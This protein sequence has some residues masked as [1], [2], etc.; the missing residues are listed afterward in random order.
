M[1]AD[2]RPARR[3]E[4]TAVVERYEW[5]FAPPGSTPPVW[6]EAVAAERVRALIDSDRATVL[7]TDD[8]SGFCTVVLD[9]P[10][11]RFGQRAWVEDLAIDPSRRSEGLGKQ[12]LDAAKQ[13]AVEHGATHLELDS[14]DGRLDAHRFYERE[15]PSWTSRCFGWWLA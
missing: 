3:T 4:T 1:T 15:Q 10:S 14:G 2:I 6:D 7:V 9:L 12:L 8:L 5:L 13:W 11:V